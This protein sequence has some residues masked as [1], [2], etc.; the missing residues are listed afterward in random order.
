M[1]VAEPIASVGITA[2]PSNFVHQCKD[3]FSREPAHCGCNS[4][5]VHAYALQ[6]KSDATA[7]VAVAN[8]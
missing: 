2:N 6:G 8:A 3:V 5:G 7:I 4:Y 1:Q